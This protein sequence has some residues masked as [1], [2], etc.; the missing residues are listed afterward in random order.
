MTGLNGRVAAL[1]VLGAVLAV[2]A[3]PRSVPPSTT[4]PA[5]AGHGWTVLRDV[6]L[7]ED[8]YFDGDSFHLKPARGDEGVFRLYFADC[9][10]TDPRLKDRMADQAKV[11][12][13]AVSR[14]PAIGKRAAEFTREFLREG[15][16]VHTRR[17]VADGDSR[18]PRH[19]AFVE[20][21]GRW[22]HEAL[23]EA[24]LARAYGKSSDLPDGTPARDHWK[25]LDSL[26]ETARK[27]GAGAW[28]RGGR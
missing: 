3:P 8:R 12:G 20:V 18:M 16:T 5:A 6:R 28:E 24:G 10:E 4:K 15:C 26:Q 22:L 19:F 11:F 7:L 27:R 14:I 9:P 21:R 25:R 17:E 13:V 1:A 23:V 2:A